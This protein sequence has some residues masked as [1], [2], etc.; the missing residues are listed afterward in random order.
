MAEVE[1]AV[2]VDSGFGNVEIGAE[3]GNEEG[4]EDV[5]DKFME[6]LESFGQIRLRQFGASGIWRL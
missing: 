1:K 6:D 5:V 2:F 4:I 3:E